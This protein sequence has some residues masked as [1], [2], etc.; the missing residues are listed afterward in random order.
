MKFKKIGL[1]VLL[2]ELADLPSE[3]MDDE[4]RHLVAGI[5]AVVERIRSIGPEL[6]AAAIATLLKEQPLALDVLRL[7]AAEARSRWRTAS[8]T[9]SAESGAAGTLSACSHAN[10]RMRWRQRSPRSGWRSG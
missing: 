5:P 7:L 2:S 4:A 6:D 9:H 8:A 3:W 10:H 1:D